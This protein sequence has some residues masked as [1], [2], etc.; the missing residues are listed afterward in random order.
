MSGYLEISNYKKLIYIPLKKLPFQDQVRKESF[1]QQI[2][3]AL[4]SITEL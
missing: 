4:L 3:S 1:F 2:F